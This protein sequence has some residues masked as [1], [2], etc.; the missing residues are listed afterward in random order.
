MAK[1]L[2]TSIVANNR[3]EYDTWRN[4]KNGPL[5]VSKAWENDFAKFLD[6]MGKRPGPGYYLKRK[7]PDLPWSKANCVWKTAGEKRLTADVVK[8][9]TKKKSTKKA[10]PAKVKET[11]V[12]L[13]PL[14]PMDNWNDPIG[15][16]DAAG[17]RVNIRFAKFMKAIMIDTSYCKIIVHDDG[18]AV[19]TPKAAKLP[20]PV[21]K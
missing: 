21:S 8:K 20:A 18:R 2:S 17:N 16:L 19:I 13:P 11:P 4:I 15:L 14:R 12:T 6:D 5:G 10:K 7:N 1:Q 3:S 9:A